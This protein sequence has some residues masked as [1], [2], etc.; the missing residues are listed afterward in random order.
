[1][2]NVQQ[3]FDQFNERIKLKRFKDNKTLQEKRD[4]VRDRLTTKLPDVFAEHDETCPPFV[5][6]NQGSYVM[7]TG[8][9]PKKGDFDIDQGLY[10]AVGSDSY[11][12]PVVLK[13]R[14]HAALVGHTKDV[15]IRR[16]CVTVFYQQ[17]EEPIYHV[18]VAVYIDGS[19]ESDGKSRLA[20][21]KEGSSEEYK[22]LR[23]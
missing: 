7:G 8:I 15:Q 17:D 5:F 18:D 12:D 23:Q 1:M 16:S 21:G 10:F 3:R 14:V 4:I 19:E 20:K 13:Q 9:K 11:P 6:A 22:S 2:A